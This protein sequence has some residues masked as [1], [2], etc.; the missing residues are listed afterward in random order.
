MDVEH[1]L[2]GP[3]PSIEDQAVPPLL[4]LPG[5]TSSYLHHLRQRLNVDSSKFRDI[6]VVVERDHQ[7]MRRR[8]GVEITEG[9][10]PLTPVHHIGPQVTRDDPAEDAIGLSLGVRAHGRQG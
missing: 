8:H 3:G 7:N 10:H 6:G 1:R 4:E 2:T 9:E 5:D